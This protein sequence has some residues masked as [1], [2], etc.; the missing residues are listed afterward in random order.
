MSRPDEEDPISILVSFVRDLSTYVY[1][2]LRFPHWKRIANQYLQEA[3]VSFWSEGLMLQ[4]RAGS[5]AVS[6]RGTPTRTQAV[7]VIPGPPDFTEVS[8]RQERYTPWKTQEIDIGSQP[9][10]EMFF[11]G[12]PARLVF[13]LLDAE[14]RNLLMHASGE[15][16]KR[17]E[18]FGGE[19]VAE[20]ADRQLSRLIP[21]LLRIGEWFTQP[22]DIRQR[23]VQ[24]ATQDPEAGV[25]LK[26]L[27]LLAHEL[28]GDP[29]TR[30]VL[31]AAC[32]D[33]SPEVRLRAGRALGAEGLPVLVKLT[34]D[35]EDDAI[36]A[37]A[38]FMLDRELPPEP[39]QSE[40][41]QDILR[42]ALDRRCHQTALA[43][44][45]AL[46]RAGDASAAGVLAKVMENEQDKLAAFAAQV[47]GT[48]GSPDAEGP[49]I[50]A[51]Q[52]DQPAL[53]V[54]AANAL[55][56]IGS[57][58]AVLPL[59]EAADRF[60]RDSELSQAT[61]Q[62]I[63]E[64]QSRLPGAS[65]GQLSLAGADAGQLSLAQAE[66]GQLSLAQAESGQLSIAT[67][68]AGQLSLESPDDTTR[69]DA[70]GDA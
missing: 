11:I 3:K 14:T 53:R 50:L 16:P 58:S 56:R 29:E 2:L 59:K 39:M 49:L 65:P 46:G 27:L 25:R 70:P 15:I 13:A 19:L 67:D 36:S 7:I 37:E 10:D 31:R 44:I 26:N 66:A 69:E 1:S 64:I 8:I 30:K 42:R 6:I 47:L 51:L 48:I 40:R 61:R 38:V 43:C 23:L 24:N 52:R 12:G 18:I 35:L 62:A 32:S 34:E 33:P 60:S 54:A 21:L 57:T 22:V 45:S 9:F 28:P 68:P 20:M 41:I 55:G 63:A 4:G 17:M 5:L